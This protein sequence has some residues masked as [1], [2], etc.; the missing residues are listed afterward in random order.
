[1]TVENSARGISAGDTSPPVR[2]PSREGLPLFTREERQLR[3]F[4]R[5]ETYLLRAFE[6]L[7]PRCFG[8][9]AERKAHARIAGG[10]DFFWA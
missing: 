5:C 2:E 1:V 7:D 4:P 3:E 6:R 8:G 9:G 10:D